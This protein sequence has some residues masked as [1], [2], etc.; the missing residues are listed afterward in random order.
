MMNMGKMMKQV[1]DMQSKMNLMQEKLN[2]TQITGLAGGELVRATI[3]G[4]YEL[5]AVAIDPKAVDPDDLEMLE[6]L[7]VAAYNDAKGQ[8]D[9]VIEEE[10]GKAMGGLSLPPGMKLPF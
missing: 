2:N 6:A 5:L 10:T 1:Q 9:K 3:N 8:I 7:I 4:K